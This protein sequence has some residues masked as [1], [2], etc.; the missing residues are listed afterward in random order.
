MVTATTWA[1]GQLFWS[2]LWATAFI[3]WIALAIHV[4][5]DLFSSSRSGVVK[6][7]WTLFVIV[8]PIVGVIVY[9][10]VY[11]GEM[12]EFALAAGAEKEART[13][14]YVRETSF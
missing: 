4:F 6:A 2:M 1:V 5:R 13:S 14:Q 10:I 3:I 9:L 7:L 12:N 8:A 11:G